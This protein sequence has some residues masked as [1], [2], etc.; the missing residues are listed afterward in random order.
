MENTAKNAQLVK[1]NDTSDGEIFNDAAIINATN[2]KDL[3]S[4]ANE[5]GIKHN[6]NKFDKITH[7]I[8]SGYVRYTSN[9]AVVFFDVDK[10]VQLS[11][12]SC[13]CRQLIF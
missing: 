1:N 13:S 11:T 12:G 4:Y 10:S 3:K 7:L 9:S 8:E 5:L 2:F 6:D